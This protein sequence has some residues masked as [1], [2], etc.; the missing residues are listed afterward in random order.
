MPCYS[1][2]KGY[3]D[4]DN[5]GLVFKRSSRTSQK[6]E[7]ACG[8]CLGCRLDRTLM[9]AMRITHEASLHVD[10]YGNSFITLTYRNKAECSGA[11][12]AAGHYVP[13]DY[14]LNKRHFQKFI[15]R[16]R[17]HFPQQIRYFHCGEYGDE[18]LRPH[19]HAA[20]FNCSF[21]DQTVFT[22]CEGI[23]TYSSPV[24]EKLWPYG[25]STVGEL[26][27]DT[28]S[29]VAGYILKKVTGTQA[30]EEYLR[31]D[32]YGV[33]YW[34][35]PPYVTMSLKPGIGADFYQ[36][37]KTD[38]FP[39]DETPVPGKGIIS[40]VPRYY[41]TILKHE[42]PQLLELVKELRKEFIR[43]HASDFTPERLMA[44]YKVALTRQKKRAN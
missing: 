13:S 21:P 2:L 7:V 30:T 11:Q 4:P 38:F 25:F 44:R 12:L 8:Q 18:T 35:Q 6:L 36:K 14:S 37:Y 29:Y 34:V 19:Y 32:E 31:S 43:R 17:K 15:K 42:N 10:H 3:K 28:A 27:F 20:L 24:L 5:G 40:K 9:W 39:S 26:N 23:T 41:E 1:P 16:L 22:E 33:A